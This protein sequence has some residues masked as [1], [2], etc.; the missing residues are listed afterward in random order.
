MK[1]GFVSM[2]LSGHMN[3]MT[4]LARKLQSRGNEVVFLGIPDAGPFVRAAN[5]SFIPFG[6]KEY[7]L[8]FVPKAWGGVAKMHGLEVMKYSI[9]ICPGLLQVGIDYLPEKIK[10]HGIDAL[11]FD[12]VYFYLELVAIHMGVPYVQVY[13]ILNLDSSGATPHGFFSWPYKT[14]QEALD[15]NVEGLQIV[16]K[17]FVDVVSVAKPYA[18]KIGLEVDW[19]NPNSTASKLAIVS[20]L[21]KEFDFPNI[22]WLPQFH[23]AGPFHD[24]AGREPVPFPWE[25]LSSEALIYASLGTLVNG[26]E[27]IYRTILKAV[28]PLQNVQLVLSVGNN[29]NPADLGPIP[30]NTIIVPSAP[31][32]E[33]LKRSVL[34]ITHAGLN[35][36]LESLAAEVPMVA[37]PIGY[38]QPGVAA[39]IAYHGVGEFVEVE[40][41]TVERLSDL[42]RRVRENPV[43]RERAHYFQKVISQARGLDFAASTIEQAFGINA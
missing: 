9:Q 17:L 18:E 2:P 3:P 25:K 5:L 4:A 30:E 32:V 38:E 36:A 29:L 1:I 21:P 8:G 35:T 26:L 11:V 33:L 6:E 22:P 27:D 19:E 41:L 34:C 28:G 42:I 16:G 7:P 43:Y 39:R 40:D 37:I 20:Q 24:G 31:Q 10:E 12:T 13:N 15:K 14:T 23:Y